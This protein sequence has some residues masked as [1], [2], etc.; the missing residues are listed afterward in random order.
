M[1]VAAPGVGLFD[2]LCAS[3][4]A[5]SWGYGPCKGLGEP[6]FRCQLVNFPDVWNLRFCKVPRVDLGQISGGVAPPS[7]ATMQDKKTF[8]IQSARAREETK[9]SSRLRNFR[10]A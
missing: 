1:V 9:A 5:R 3:G 10:E 8:T 2:A 6:L 7:V 4:P